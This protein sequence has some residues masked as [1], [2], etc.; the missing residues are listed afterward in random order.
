MDKDDLW[1]GLLRGIYQNSLF[2]DVDDE[3]CLMYVYSAG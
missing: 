1:Q 3:I 2:E